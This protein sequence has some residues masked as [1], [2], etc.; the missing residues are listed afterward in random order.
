ML[1]LYILFRKSKVKKCIKKPNFFIIF[2]NLCIIA[3]KICKISGE[4]GIGY[5]NL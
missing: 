1:L 5:A 2:Y 3:D 4:K